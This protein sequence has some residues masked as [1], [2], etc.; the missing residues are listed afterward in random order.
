MLL[1][2]FNFLNGELKNYPKIAISII[3]TIYDISIENKLDLIILFF[4]GFIVFIPTSNNHKVNIIPFHGYRRLISYKGEEIIKAV[5]KSD[6]QSS[7]KE[8]E[9]FNEK[10]VALKNKV[11]SIIKSYIPN[12]SNK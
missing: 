10:V 5:K 4:E 12:K 1:S 8:E 3:K 9:I 2:K 6:L 7:I 11:N